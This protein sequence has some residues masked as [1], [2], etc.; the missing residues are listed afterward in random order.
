MLRLEI[1][2]D[3]NLIKEIQMLLKQSGIQNY[4]LI[5]NVKGNGTSGA[6]FGNPAAPGL[7]CVLTTVVTESQAE[8][9]L[10]GVRKFKT[11]TPDIGLKVFISEIKEIV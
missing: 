11:T 8:T 3:E 2:F 7:N 4:T 1:V 5:D 9:L 6:R 10:C